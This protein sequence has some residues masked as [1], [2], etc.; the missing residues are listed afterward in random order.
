MIK[1]TSLI[2][3]YFNNFLVFITSVFVCYI[4]TSIY[5]VDNVHNGNNKEAVSSNSS[6]RGDSYKYSYMNIDTLNTFIENFDIKNNTDKINY[7]YTMDKHVKISPEVLHELAVQYPKMQS[8]NSYTDIDTAN[9]SIKDILKDNTHKILKWINSDNKNKLFLK[10]D[11][12]QVIGYGVTDYDVK[13]KPRKKAVVIL[14]K[15]KDDKKSFYIITSYPVK[16]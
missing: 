2:Q 5:A 6:A 15:K 3:K 4:V 10:K 14:M 9:A 12:D 13:E 1:S 11:F 7:N 8:F 16:M